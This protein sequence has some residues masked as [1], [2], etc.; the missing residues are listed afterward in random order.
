MNAIINGT[1]VYYE[2]YGDGVP[3]IC[4]HGFPED[5]RAVSGCFEPVF[6]GV[7]GYR[8]LYLDLP[9]LGKSPANPLVENADDMLNTLFQFVEQVIG[10]EHF[11]LIGQSYGGYLS[12]GLTQQLPER[13]K[14]LYLLCPCVVASREH[15]TLTARTIIRD[16]G[17][18]LSADDNLADYE[19]FAQAATII[20][21]A[22]WERYKAEILPGLQCADKEFVERYQ[23]DGYGLSIESELK[24]IR[25]EKPTT[26]LMG[27]QDD[28]VGYRDAYELIECFPRA[29]FEILDGAGHNLQI[30]QPCRFEDSVVDW[31]KR[32]EHSLS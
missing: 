9:G 18:A 22:T 10:T 20:T 12:L 2:Q 29:S 19:V 6:Q 14:G 11:Y 13:I 26:F 7:S 21:N 17:I 27:R 16:D 1:P 8:R 32:I 23:A 3:I 4:I 30:E 25:F 31:L 15:R 24:N 28:C 5:H